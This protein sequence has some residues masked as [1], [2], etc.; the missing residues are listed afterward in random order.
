MPVPINFPLFNSI[1]KKISTVHVTS[2]YPSFV[3]WSKATRTCLS[4]DMNKIFLNFP[5]WSTHLGNLNVKLIDLSST[6]VHFDYA[7]Q[8]RC[9]LQGENDKY[10]EKQI[11]LIDDVKTI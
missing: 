4:K 2:D 7:I 9:N 5:W 1:Y 10:C 3:I 8:K 6:S 11:T